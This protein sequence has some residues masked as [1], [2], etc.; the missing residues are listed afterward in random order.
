CLS[1]SFGSTTGCLAC[2]VNLVNF[3]CALV[4]S[5]DQGAFA[6][7][8][9]PP[10]D[11]ASNHATRH[12]ACRPLDDLTGGSSRV[13]QL[14]VNVDGDMACRIYDSCKSIAVVGETT[15]MQSGLVSG[16]M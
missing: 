6:S 4:C 3:W 16:H 12:P 9:D 5:P 13:L 7:M 8:H 11:Q 1:Y 2:A 14:D 10:F 15:A